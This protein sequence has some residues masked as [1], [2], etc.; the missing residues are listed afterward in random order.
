[1]RKMKKSCLLMLLLSMLTL[2]GC[3]VL[4]SSS[5]ES[6]NSRDNNKASVSEQKEE[7]EELQSCTVS[8][9]TFSVSKE[10][11]PM[12]GQ[13]GAFTT[14]DQKVVYHLQGASPLGSQ[15]PA[16]VYEGFKEFY[17]AS[18]EIVT[19]DD[20]LSSFQTADKVDVKIGRIEMTSGGVWFIIDVLIVPQKNY[21]VTF[22][23]QCRDKDD[24]TMDIREVTSTATIDIGTK[25]YITG[26]TFIGA[27]DSELCL[28]KDGSFAYYQTVDE[29]DGARYVG[30]YDVYYGQKAVDKVVSMSEY[31]VTEEELEQTLSA[32]MNGYKV[33]GSDTLSYFLEE[34][35]EEDEDEDLQHVCKD[36]FYA[37]ILH[38]DKIVDET[39]EEQE[40]GSDTLYMG[41]YLPEL[42]L[43]DLVNANTANRIEWNLCGATEE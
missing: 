14:K 11:E 21:V 10:L 4:Q 5:F 3:S 42:K 12:E 16:E 32:N 31:G 22:A 38:N 9:V 7:K 43:A 25:D 37:V 20:K 13:E 35:E 40:I 30:T 18:Y 41:Y 26:N 24:L 15:T 28:K 23:A 17:G 2:S 33:G 8:Q 6:R 39:G 36:T 19:S 29:H 1:M 27:D 34:D